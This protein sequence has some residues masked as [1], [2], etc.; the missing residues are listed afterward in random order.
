MIAH[1]R[2]VRDLRTREYAARRVQRGNTRKEIL[3]IL[4]RYIARELFPIVLESLSPPTC[5]AV[6]WHRG[7]NPQERLSKEIRRRTDVVGIFPDRGW[8]IRLVGI[9]LYEQHGDWAVVRRYMSPHSLAKA[10]AEV[11][12]G[13][14]IEEVK[15]QLG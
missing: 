5:T 8:V 9:V 11:I 3:R 15:G 13:Q 14:G 2:M 7:I 1:V 12:E 4:K 10:R 6:V